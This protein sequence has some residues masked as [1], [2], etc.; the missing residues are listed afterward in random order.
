MRIPPAEQNAIPAILAAV[1]V[2]DG[3][4]LRVQMPAKFTGNLAAKS[5]ARSAMS[6]PATSQPCLLNQMLL[7]P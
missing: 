7:R 4:H 6:N 3:C 2:F 5:T 1:E